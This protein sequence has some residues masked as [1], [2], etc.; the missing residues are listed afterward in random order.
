MVPRRKK[1]RIDQSLT[2]PMPSRRNPRSP[3]RAIQSANKDAAAAELTGKTKT[4]E[5]PRHFGE[6]TAGRKA[7]S[8]KIR[9]AEFQAIEA[10]EEKIKLTYDFAT[11][12]T[13]TRRHNTMI[14]LADMPPW[15]YF[16]KPSHMAFHDLTTTDK[17]TCN[18]RSL[19]GLGLKFCPKLR[20]GNFN[21][22]KTIDRFDRD[23][24]IKL[25][26]AGS[27]N[28][29]E[30]AYD[31]KIY[32]RSDWDPPEWFIPNPVTRRLKRFCAAI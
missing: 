7:E 25:V 2:T 1:K 18:L 28:K 30:A 13:K 29:L 5:T 10:V 17:P 19:L 20:Y 26:M 11:N 27:T 9:Q 22:S 32:V 23:L 15:Y 14:C 4:P 12:P 31:P 24:T 6:A 16:N 8:T 3:S 21:L